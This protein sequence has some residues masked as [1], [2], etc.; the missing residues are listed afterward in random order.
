MAS[1]LSPLP[2]RSDIFTAR[3]K[4]RKL[5]NFGLLSTFTFGAYLSLRVFFCVA[6]MEIG[7]SV[8]VFTATRKTMM[9]F[10]VPLTL[11]A[12]LQNLVVRVCGVERSINLGEVFVMF[13]INEALI[14]RDVIDKVVRHW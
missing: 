13:R 5:R 3:A 10:V 12:I 14:R 9:A 6:I 4:S 2:S 11:S 1:H 8:G 7:F